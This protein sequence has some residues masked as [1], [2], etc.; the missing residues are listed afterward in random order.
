LAEPNRQQESRKP[1]YRS[2]PISR[3]PL[4]PGIVALWF[5]ALVGLGSFALSTSL[6]ERAVLASGID[7]AIPA[8]APPLGMTARLL[9]GL[10]LGAAGVAIGW[11]LARRL[12]HAQ[13]APAPKVFSVSD[14]DL[15]DERLPWPSTPEP[16]AASEPARPILDP[17]S[18]TTEADHV[19][20][21][22]AFSYP[23]PEAKP[24][25]TAAERIASA[26]LHDLS[27]VE[28]VERLAIALNRR[29]ERLGAMP[30]RALDS[31]PD[32]DPDDALG[33]RTA[34]I[35]EPDRPVV[36]FPGFSDRQH[37][38]LAASISAPPPQ[39]TEKALRE[40]LAELQRMSGRA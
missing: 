3:H 12:A 16:R 32:R 37:G 8:A 6:I 14:A 4:F 35:P 19:P 1:G 23:A 21:G 7:S 34:S 20:A 29:Q 2:P 36:R 17:A 31:S 40:A 11:A 22:E 27:H 24:E 15:E 25:P 38:R 10:T 39:E 26:S 9:L 5:A 28:L 18:L 33:E 13:N 30:S